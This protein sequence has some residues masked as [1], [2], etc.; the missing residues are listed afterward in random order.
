MRQELWEAYVYAKNLE[1][2]IARRLTCGRAFRAETI[3]A[4]VYHL[5]RLEQD[6]MNHY[7]TWLACV[8]QE[9]KALFPRGTSK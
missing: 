7:N 6:S 5:P 1:R 9:C 8:A 3:L 4:C 2:A